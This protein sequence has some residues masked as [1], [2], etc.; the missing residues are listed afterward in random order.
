[1]HNHHSHALV[2]VWAGLTGGCWVFA[3]IHRKQMCSHMH[4][5]FNA[6]RRPQVCWLAVSLQ[7][8]CA[9]WHLFSRA[10]QSSRTAP[11]ASLPCSFT[12]ALIS[13]ACLCLSGCRYGVKSHLVPHCHYLKSLGISEEE[14]P[15]LIL[16]RPQVLVSTLQLF[17]NVA[18]FSDVGWCVNLVCLTAAWKVQSQH[19]KPSGSCGMGGVAM[20]AIP[21]A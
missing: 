6:P 17:L 18:N 4:C 19:C 14:L 1:M 9:T 13:S 12:Q 21:C 8:W 2:S 20:L 3:V 16:A 5:S 15:Q 10:P 7:L 11:S